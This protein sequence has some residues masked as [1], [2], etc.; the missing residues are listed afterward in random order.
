MGK[1]ATVVGLFFVL[2]IVLFCSV[3]SVVVNPGQEVVLVDRPYFL[4]MRVFV[5]NR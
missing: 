4:V 5:Q 1:L 2:L 3:S